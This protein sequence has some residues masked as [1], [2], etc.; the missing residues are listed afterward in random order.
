M[1]KE[2]ECLLTSAQ[3]QAKKKYEIYRT[4]YMK[5][6]QNVYVEFFLKSLS[7]S[8]LLALFFHK[9][10]TLSAPT[11]VQNCFKTYEICR[12]MGYPIRV[13]KYY[14]HQQEREKAN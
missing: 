3:G 11:Y 10:S 1:R 8:L 5:L 7:I 13:I 4:K 2:I 6:E 9:I 12:N 14:E